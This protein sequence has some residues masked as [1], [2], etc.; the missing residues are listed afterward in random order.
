MQPLSLT[1]LPETQRAQKLPVNEV[2]LHE[3]SD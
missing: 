1:K 3:V 2:L